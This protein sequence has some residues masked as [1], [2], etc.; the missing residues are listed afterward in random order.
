MSKAFAAPR[1]DSYITRRFELERR[2]L[3][4]HG[5]DRPAVVMLSMAGYELPDFA[6]VVDY[7]DLLQERLAA[8]SEQA[9]RRTTSQLHFRPVL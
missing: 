1:Y 3:R 8:E 2:V 9:G 7:A 6:I 5:L 4:E